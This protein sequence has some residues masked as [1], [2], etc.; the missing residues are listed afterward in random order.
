MTDSLN[1]YPHSLKVF[2]FEGDSELGNFRA[3]LI[4]HDRSPRDLLVAYLAMRD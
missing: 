3:I 2:T 4:F 1:E